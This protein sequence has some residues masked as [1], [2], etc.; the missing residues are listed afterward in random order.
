MRA[1]VKVDSTLLLKFVDRFPAASAKSISI[2]TERVGAKVEREAKA[3][4]PVVHGNLR[5][6]IRFIK[7]SEIAG[8]VKSF[9]NYSGFVHGA[10]FHENKRKRKETPFLTNALSSAESFIEQERGK[11]IKNI[12]KNI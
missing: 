11:V 4:A 7:S 2:F 8:V 12:I 9:A 6:Q 10:P 3:G 1:S 5:R